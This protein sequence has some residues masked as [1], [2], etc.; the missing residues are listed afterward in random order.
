MRSSSMSAYTEPLA[1]RTVLPSLLTSHTACSDGK[2][3]WISIG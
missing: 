1:R 2:K 3:V